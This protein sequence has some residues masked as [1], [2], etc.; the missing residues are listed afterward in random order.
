MRQTSV[1]KDCIITFGIS[2]VLFVYEVFLSRFFSAILAYNFVFIAISLATLGAGFGGYVA[3]RSALTIY[4]ARY[5]WLGMFALVMLSAVFM[6]YIIPFRG[7][8]FYAVTAFPPFLIGGALIAA[9]LQAHHRQLHVIYFSDLVGAGLGAVC[10]VWFMNILDPVQTIFILGTVALFISFVLIAKHSTLRLKIT[11][12]LVL[13]IAIYNI[14]EP[15]SKEM[16]FRAFTTSPNHVFNNKSDVKP[17]F[18]EWNSLA[19]TDVYDAGDGELLYITIDGGAV[20]PISKYTGNLKQVDYLTRTTSYLAFQDILKERALI[21]GAGGGQEVLT[22]QIAGFKQIDAVDINE[23]SFKAVQKMSRF[24]GDVFNQPGVSAFVSDGRTFIRQ[25]KNQYDIIYLSLVKKESE[26]G[27]GIALTENYLFTQEAIEEYINKLKP[28]GR[29]AFLLHDEVEMLKV[30]NA[31]EK[32]L[33]S[34]GV[35]E[36]QIHEHIAVIG[37][38][39]HL[40]H[41]VWGM[42]KTVITRPLLIISQ[43]PFT[44]QDARQLKTEAENIQQIPLHVPLIADRLSAIKDSLNKENLDLLSNRD[45]KPFFYQ[46]TKGVP[47]S[48]LWLLAIVFTISLLFVRKKRLPYG[49]IAYISGIGIGFMIIETTLIQRLILPLGHPTYAFV[50]VLSVLLVSGGIGSMF[51]SHWSSNR[52]TR[53]SPLLWVAVLTIGLNLLISWYQEE[54]IYL[55]L[56]YRLILGAI[57]LIPLGF[58]MGMPFPFGLSLL[59]ERQVSISWAINGLMTIAGSLL[60]VLISINLGFTVALVIGASLY[61]LLYLFQPRLSMQG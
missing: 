39:Q 10:S 1:K 42:N 33:Q 32:A 43:N 5:L 36:S 44:G 40:G 25:T 47:N 23:G 13:L 34:Q 60:A 35:H 14:I 57:V 51:S 28:G 15:F 18:S 21:I 38:Y 58:F 31:A 2:F 4:R 26:N 45:D 3:Y 50:L 56:L 9:I 54:M 11:Y 17:V 61:G 55:P 7:M 27:L 41:V 12:T 8:W 20:S 6:M 30:E 48:L 59:S 53:F 19:K 24:S 52:S 49:N 16:F 37:T 29:L 46:K 22:A